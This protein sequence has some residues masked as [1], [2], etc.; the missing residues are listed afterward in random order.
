MLRS[1][2]APSDPSSVCGVGDF[3]T[4]ILRNSSDA[5]VLK[6]NPRPR[7][8]PPDASVDP[9]V[10]SVSIPLM[11]TRVKSGFNPRTVIDRPS[12]LSRSIDTPG[13]RWIDSARL[14]SGKSAISSAKITSTVFTA[15]RFSFKA[16]ARLLRKPVTIISLSSG[17]ASAG[18]CFAS[19]ANAVP[20]IKTD[21]DAAAKNR[22]IF[23]RALRSLNKPIFTPLR[24]AD[25]M[26]PVSFRFTTRWK[27]A[28]HLP[29][30]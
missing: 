28:H 23:G 14:R 2:T 24:H 20:V 3:D 29:T 11:R 21:S 25:D 27:P 30:G 6:S 12:P 1:T 4:L 13:M 8:V 15:S 16:S 7:L 10:A 5:N 17:T 18:G 22:A 19:C 26:T 9:V